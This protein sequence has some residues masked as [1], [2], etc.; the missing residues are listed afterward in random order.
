VWQHAAPDF[1]LPIA[2]HCSEIGTLFTLQ[3][4]KNIERPFHRNW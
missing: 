1:F 3:P 2:L 4:K